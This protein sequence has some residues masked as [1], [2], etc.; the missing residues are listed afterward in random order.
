MVTTN[1]DDSE[2][3]LAV[4]TLTRFRALSGFLHP[5]PQLFSK[6]L[7]F[8]VYYDSYLSGRINVSYV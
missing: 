6:S 5:A 8:D 4:S 1:L 7:Y 3:S 2:F